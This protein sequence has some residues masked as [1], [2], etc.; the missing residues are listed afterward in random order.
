MDNLQ[1]SFDKNSSNEKVLKVNLE[2]M[3]IDMN[4]Y[5]FKSD[6]LNILREKNQNCIIDIRELRD[7][8]IVGM[9][10]LAV[11][12]K[13]LYNSGLSLTILSKNHSEV[14]RLFTLT[15]FDSLLNIKR[16]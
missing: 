1:V 7:I 3:L 8:D 5:D 6:L 10:A 11:V 4:A 14:E 16:A 15:K 12:H 2:G 13:E 9:N